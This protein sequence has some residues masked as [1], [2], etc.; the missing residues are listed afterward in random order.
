[1]GGGRG[2]VADDGCHG[3]ELRASRR[4][5]R[6][7]ALRPREGD[8]GGGATPGESPRRIRQRLLYAGDG[9]LQSGR[10]GG[11][12]R[13][14]RDRAG[15]W[16]VP[17]GE[18]RLLAPLP[19]EEASGRDARVRSQGAGGGDRLPG[20]EETGA[21]RLA[22]ATGGGLGATLWRQAPVR[23]CRSLV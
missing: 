22:P 18:A 9:F 14:A 11:A 6:G 20:C 16:R 2:H 15:A 3:A 10:G 8:S 4:R 23:P 7:R 17:Q 5:Q 1:R 12:A 13:A 19:D 21:G